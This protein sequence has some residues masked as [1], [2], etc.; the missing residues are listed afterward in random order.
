MAWE[1]PPLAINPHRL[2]QKLCFSLEPVPCRHKLASMGVAIDKL[3]VAQKKY[4]DA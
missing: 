1:F 3:S 4:L 2:F